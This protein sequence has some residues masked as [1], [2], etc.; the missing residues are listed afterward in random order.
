MM[1]SN[2]KRLS[3]VTRETA[4]KRVNKFAD[5]LMPVAPK[6]KV[7]SS[8]EEATSA[9]APQP[10]PVSVEPIETR[11]QPTPSVEPAPTPAKTERVRKPSGLSVEDIVNT[12]AREG[13]VFN[14]MIRVT[15]DH[16]ELLRLMAFKYRKP[17][18]VIVHNLM[19]LLE[20]AYQKEQ[21]KDV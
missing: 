2:E 16:H 8:R 10:D 3:D 15:D 12:P 7:D 18:N 21:Q 11:A 14:K 9:V 5:S 20:Q 1:E 17:M 19:S 13:D 6:N 4:T